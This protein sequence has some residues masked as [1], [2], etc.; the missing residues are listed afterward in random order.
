MN[1][2]LKA[3]ALILVAV[4][5]MAQTLPRPTGP[6]FEPI[7]DW[8][9]KAGIE[10]AHIV[11]A[12]GDEILPQIANRGTPQEGGYFTMFQIVNVSEES[13]RFTVSFFDGDGEPLRI[14]L[15]VH[16]DDMTGTIA[17]GFSGTLTRGGYGAQMTVPNGASDVVGYA[18]VKMDPA[19]SIAVNATYVN[20]N[21]GLPPF[22]AGIPL[23]SVRHKTAFM[24]YLADRGFTPALALVSLEAQEVTLIA[25]S[26]TTGVELCRE[27]LEF[28]AN[29]HKAFVLNEHLI[30]TNWSEGTLEIRGNPLLPASL[31]GIGFEGHTGGAFV[32]QPIWTNEEQVTGGEFAPVSRN[33]FDDR[34][35]GMRLQ[36]NLRTFYLDFV[37]SRRFEEARR[38]QTLE[39][40]YTYYN[41]GANTARL[42]LSYDDDEVET[43]EHNL[44][45]TSGITG[46]ST[47][48][49]VGAASEEFTWRLMA[50]PEEME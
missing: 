34:F 5:A 48:E 18:V 37:M 20:L 10:P 45:F 44:T 50:I 24:P 8:H 1:S 31:A 13:A 43:C 33:D 38:G 2:L 49:C 3:A 4:S 22:M 23:S 21:P 32:T 17:T 39:G 29:E 36:T 6:Y 7:P 42:R 14:P 40:T 15:A 46:T 41:T 30:C 9:S 11:I 26:G 25:R 35:V 12:P 16:A 47:F 27:T 28:E 19:E